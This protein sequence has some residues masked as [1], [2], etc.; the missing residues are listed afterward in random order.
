MEEIEPVWP[1]NLTRE[2]RKLAS[3]RRKDFEAALKKRAKGTGWR[4][5]EGTIFRKT[6][7]WFIA[8]TP[9]LTWKEG[10]RHQLMIKPMA[11]DTLFWEI[12]D[13]PE[14]EK[15]PLSFRTNGAWVLRPP[16][17]SQFV[18]PEKNDLTD[19]ANLALEWTDAWC[20]RNLAE[21]EINDILERL[22]P[23]E[24]TKSHYRAVAICLLIQMKEFT[25]ASVL[26]DNQL[27][28]SGGFSVGINRTFYD[29]ARDWLANNAIT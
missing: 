20:S 26:I 2:E 6:G 17:I 29:M 28:D 21:Y 12:V 15:L 10:I 8:S 27:N 19:L 1:L 7:D 13:L 18:I 9:H 4:Y 5:R 22:K 24:R 25:Q 23:L 14:N 16:V 11:L 3:Q